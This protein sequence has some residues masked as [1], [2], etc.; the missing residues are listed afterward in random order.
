MNKP[1]RYV[2]ESLIYLTLLSV[3]VAYTVVSFSL[4]NQTFLFANA[5]ASLVSAVMFVINI[6]ELI[7]SFI[8]KKRGRR[9]K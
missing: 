5:G 2:I 4:D 6:V 1:V 3:T 7:K 8:L 9:Y